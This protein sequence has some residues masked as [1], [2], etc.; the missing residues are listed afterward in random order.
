M[1]EKLRRDPPKYD[2]D[3]IGAFLRSFKK[4]QRYH[5]RMRMHKINDI[6]APLCQDKL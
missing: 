3:N 1:N 5:A 2:I 4:E 6:N